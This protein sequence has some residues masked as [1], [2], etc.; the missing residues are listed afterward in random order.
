MRRA[1]F[2]SVYQRSASSS[3]SAVSAA[4]QLGDVAEHEPLA[5]GV[6]EDAA[7]AAHAL[8]DEDPADRR[9]PHHPGRMELDALHVDELG[10]RPQGERVTVA[11]VL[12]GVGRDL[13]GLA[14]AAGGQ[15]D[16]GG[17]EDDEA[18]RLAPVGEGTGDAAAV[19]EQARDRALHEH[20]D[21]LVHGVVLEG[22]D[23]L[24]SG[25]VSDVRE[26]G[27]AVPSEVPLE[28]APVLGPVE[29]GAPLLELEHPVGRLLRLDL[30]HP[31]VVEELAAAQRVAEVHPPVVLGIDVAEGGGDPALCHHGVGLA[32]QRLAHE[33]GARALG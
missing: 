19:L 1:L 16:G 26:P 32:E 6:P 7:V 4:E 13:V 3:V 33:R 9:R 21:A 29:Q 5:V 8:G 12:P 23:H 10:A 25:A 22:A 11:G 30:H 18:S 17:F 24:E 15:H 31:P 27:V 20:V 28:D 2:L 14:D